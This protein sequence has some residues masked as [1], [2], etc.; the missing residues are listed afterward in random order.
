MLFPKLETLNWNVRKETLQTE[1]GIIVPNQVGI[2]RDDTNEVL[3]V[4]G[5]DYFPYQ[6]SQLIEL[7]ER[8][9]NQTSLEIERSGFFGKGER[10]FIQ[11]KSNDLNL[12]GDKI[13]GFLTG[14]NSF[15]GST[16]LGFGHSNVTISCMNTFFSSYRQVQNKV[17][18]T[19]NMDLKIDDICRQLD[20]LVVEEK[21]IFDTIVKMSETRFDD[22]LRDKVTRKLF[23]IKKEV[24]DLNDDK[25][26][27][28]VKRNQLS[29]FYVDMSGEL[30]QKGDNL[31]G[32][33]SGVTKFTTHSYQKKDST[34]KKLF[35]TIG[36]RERVIFKELS[37]LV[38]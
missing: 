14:V 13:R 28:S 20:K 17:R 11:L 5:K 15:D 16:S 22:I 12:N 7:L 8:I 30:Q 2:V 26:V 9:S 3:S 33:F 36:Q 24:T 10:V 25:Q 29:K 34:E 38:S 21:N 1:S 4:M 19:K 35:G 32:L 18:H 31:W 27:S 6:N 23:D 37:E